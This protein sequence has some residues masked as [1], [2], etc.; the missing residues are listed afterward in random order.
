M[1]LT[2][3]VLQTDGLG[4]PH[5]P[6]SVDALGIDISGTFNGVSATS[7]IA[8]VVNNASAVISITQTGYFPYTMTVDNVYMA[9]KTIDVVMV[10]ITLTSDPEYNLVT[11]AFFEFIDPCSFVVDAYIA[12]SYAGNISWYINNTLYSTGT[13]MKL[14]FIAPG[15]YQV[16]VVTENGDWLR[17]F[18][19][20]IQGNVVA[21]T[22][23]PIADY[24]VLDDTTNTTIAEYRPD[25][26]L[27]LSSANLPIATDDLTCYARGEEITVT[28]SWTLN[29]PG[30]VAA[31]HNIIYTVTDPSGNVVTL[32]QDTFPLNV[33]PSFA[34]I[35]F[36]LE[37]VGTYK[38]DAKIVDLDCGTEF[39][40][41]SCIETC[42]FVH[43]EYTA[44]DNYT[45]ENRS[46]VTPFDYSIS[47]FGIVGVLTDGTLL[48]AESIDIAFANP[49]LFIMTV[50]YFD[51]LGAPVEEQYIISNH[52]EIEKC[53]SGYI[54]DLLCG[55]GDSCAPCPPDNELNQVLLMTYTYF[56]KLNREY[57]LN[58][59]Y[60]G[61]SQ[62]KLDE[63][64]SIDQVLNKLA[65]FCSRRGC[66]NSSNSAFSDGVDAGQRVYTW[67]GPDQTCDCNPSASGSYYNTTKPGYCGGC[68][69]GVTV[70]SS[71][72]CSTCS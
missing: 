47:Q 55:T 13:K 59:F 69:G 15:D 71:S 44:C 56:M 14:S 43:I 2:L 46:S 41:Q 66:T 34:A 45:V 58:N 61:L 22:I 63:L 17:L 27:D 26:A 53:I 50:N 68:G 23:D 1:N 10:P 29:R 52:C 39:P 35:V 6:L 67:V 4:N 51:A 36:T 18:G 11:P 12:S 30:A 37:E 64:T 62:G 48:P 25:F 40:I 21:G 24:L 31:D 19:T 65:L 70:S 28:P 49:G 7:L 72:G 20:T 32:A 9:N 5:I 42:N 54:T 38:V 33:A 3:N 57:S 16:K 60:T 8:V